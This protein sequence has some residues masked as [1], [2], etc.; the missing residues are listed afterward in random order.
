[1]YRIMHCTC[2]VW[3][4][5]LG[6]LSLSLFGRGN[7]SPVLEVRIL[8]SEIL[9]SAF[10]FCMMVLVQ[11]RLQKSQIKRNVRLTTTDRLQITDWD[12]D[13]STYRGPPFA[14]PPTHAKEL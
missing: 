9:E 1:M 13:W 12:W 2:L 7:P 6:S 3:T 11:N 4:W 14:I 5:T 10:C 8:K